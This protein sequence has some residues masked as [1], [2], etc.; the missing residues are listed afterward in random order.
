MGRARTN[1]KAR[2]RSA[3]LR[4]AW[5]KCLVCN[6]VPSNSSKTGTP[7]K[8]YD[9]NDFIF[10]LIGKIRTRIK[11]LG[12]FL[13]SLLSWGHFKNGHGQKVVTSLWVVES[14][15]IHIKCKIKQ[16][17]N[18]IRS[19]H[20]F[21]GKVISSQTYLIVTGVNSCDLAKISAGQLAMRHRQ[22]ALE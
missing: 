21:G 12:C 1:A 4:V 11:I 7:L 6:R 9:K 20:L 17:W 19:L 3:D 8:N 16:P 15:W 10:Q 18:Q 13:A 22:S 5:F 2:T 14:G